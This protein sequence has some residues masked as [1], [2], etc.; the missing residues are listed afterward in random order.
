MSKYRIY[1]AVPGK[2]VCWGTVMGVVRSTAKHEALPF[3]GG[4]GF[5]GQEDFNVLWADAM[6]LYE[7]GEITHFAMLTGTSVPTPKSAGLMCCL[8]KWIN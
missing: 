5:S 4:F 7:A 2:H 6:N 3:N 8:K 1:L